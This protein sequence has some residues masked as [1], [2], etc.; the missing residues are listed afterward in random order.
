MEE[1]KSIYPSILQ[2]IGM[3]VLVVFFLHLFTISLFLLT[4]HKIPV[5]TAFLIGYVL[6]MGTCIWI[7]ISFWKEKNTIPLPSFFKSFNIKIALLVIISTL[8]LN[9]GIT[10]F[11]LEFIPLSESSRQTL[12]ENFGNIDA[13]LLIAMIISA[14]I[15][16]EYI[17]RGLMLEG[18]L[19]NYAPW[20]AIG[21]SSLLFGTMHVNPLQLVSAGLGG[22]FIGWI[23]YKSRNLGYCILIHF[24]IN[25][26]GYIQIKLF[27][28]EQ[29]FAKGMIEL[30]GGVWNVLGIVLVAT[31]VLFTCIWQLNQLFNK[32]NQPA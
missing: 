21:I 24:V 12:I 30:Y 26:T 16:E 3:T 13:Y 7:F 1:T 19:K 9:N 14:P 28:V 18:L 27:G 31:L 15:F 23:Y 5:T 20:V 10:T 8:A 6:A 11:L 4:N 22:L 25:I 17:F 32:T 2:A 29:M